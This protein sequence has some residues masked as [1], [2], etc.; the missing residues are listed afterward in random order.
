VGQKE[1]SFNH[2]H[3]HTIE[4]QTA[5]LRFNAKV[6]MARFR[7]VPNTFVT[8]SLQGTNIAADHKGNL[9]YNQKDIRGYYLHALDV[10]FKINSDAYHIN[11]D[12][13]VTSMGSGATTSTA[14]LQVDVNAGTFGPEP[15]TGVGAGVAIGSSFTQNLSDFRVVNNSEETVVQHTYRMAA[16]RQGKAYDRPE[17]LADMSVGGQWQGAPLLEVPELAISNLPV[18][19]QAIFVSREPEGADLVL[20]VAFK[21]HFMR[22]EKTFEVVV[23]DLKTD[24]QTWKWG[25]SYKLPVSTVEAD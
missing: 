8:V 3:E 25:S 14:Q 4:R 2:F 20:D 9:T 19:S 17:D 7:E 16:T 18:I 6:T 11:Q 15:T 23:V 21:A 5:A 24:E 22:V 1:I 12:A 10:S 13:P